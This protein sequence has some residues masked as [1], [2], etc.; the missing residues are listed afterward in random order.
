MPI[1]SHTSFP[2]SPPALLRLLSVCI[3]QL[4]LDISYKWWVE[5]FVANLNSHL[6]LLPHLLCSLVQLT[7]PCFTSVLMPLS[8]S[9]LLTTA[10]PLVLICDRQV[11]S[12]IPFLALLKFPLLTVDFH[13]R[14]QPVLPF[15]GGQKTFP[16]HCMFWLWHFVPLIITKP[17]SCFDFSKQKVSKSLETFSVTKI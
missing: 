17:V 7:F 16:F 3:D 15:L 2:L 6:T 11:T 14:S 9:E 4:I 10:R 1:R 12:F 13:S 8:L 5:V